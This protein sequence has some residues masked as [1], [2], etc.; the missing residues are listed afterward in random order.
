MKSNNVFIEDLRRLQ[1]RISFKIVA[2][3]FLQL[4]FLLPLQAGALESTKTAAPPQLGEPPSYSELPA[5]TLIR[6]MSVPADRTGGWSI[7][8]S[9]RQVS[10]AFYNSVYLAS[11]DITSGWNGSVAS[12]DEGTTTGDFKNGVLVRVNYFRA[13]AGVP[14]DVTFD[15][16]YSAK[17]Q[18]A[19]LM[20][21]RNNTLSH[22]PSSSWECYSVDG[23]EAAGSSNLSLGNYGWDAVSGQ[24]RDNGSN[25]TLV[26]HR[27]WILYPQTQNMGTGDVPPSSSYSSANSL[28]VFDSHYSDPRPATRETY[29]AWPPPGYV[30]YQVVPPRWSFSYPGADFSSATV[31]MSSGGSSVTVNQHPIA[32]GYGDN[33]LA[34]VADGLDANQWYTRWPQPAADTTYTV[35]ISG[36]VIS[37]SPT[38]ITY[39]V[40]V[41]D[42]TVSGPGDEYAVIRGPRFPL[43][44]EGTAYSFTAVS[45]AESYEVLQ[46]EL[47]EGDYLEGGENGAGGI[48]DNTDAG[49]EL[50]ANGA[51]ASGSYS[52]HLAMPNAA[53]NSFAL[54]PAFVPSATST[55]EFAS[56]LG[57]ATSAQ[58][59][60]VQ[61]SSDDGQAWQTLYSQAGDGSLGESGFTSHTISLADYAGKFVQ[62]RFL[63]DFQS[64]SY[65]YQTS[66]NVGWLV[67]DINITD[68]FEVIDSTVLP[69]D[70][71]LGFTFTKTSNA[72]YAMAVRA[73]PWEGYP[74]LEWGPLFF[75]MEKP[76]LQD[77][78]QMLEGIQAGADD[79]S[80]SDVISVLQ[81][82]TGQ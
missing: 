78:V 7:D 71:S 63:Y 2:V 58:V 35:T 27:R 74:G 15:N 38:N 67:D 60:K 81:V 72:P 18:Q 33:T 16:I 37:G 22:S 23:D 5:F 4:F 73:I 82:V 1:C 36:V 10:R 3:I 52:F 17:S 70:T 55:L 19:A 57:Y 28:W 50:R 75:T 61:I 20:M 34:W 9:S 53:P 6:P 21:S 65:Y 12:C 80:L 49:Y 44:G 79:Y 24:M 64:G 54:I 46:A 41:I 13:M 30:P 25:N 32:N 26:G 8:P 31:S 59:A 51:A 76:G 47:G 42:P 39:E 62:F 43:F 68:G 56:R 40:T 48:T 29:V 66:T 69:A 77:A 45:M 11:E 14:S